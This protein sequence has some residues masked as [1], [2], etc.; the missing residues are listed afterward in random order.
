[1][2]ISSETQNSPMSLS[3]EFQIF[4][5]WKNIYRMNDK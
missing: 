3:K 2:N 1:M 5:P 4:G